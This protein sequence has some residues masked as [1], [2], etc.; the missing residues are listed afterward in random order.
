MI[1]L[2]KRAV[3]ALAARSMGVTTDDLSNGAERQ[4]SQRAIREQRLADCRRYAEFLTP[5]VD[6]WSEDS[7]RWNFGDETADMVR[8]MRDKE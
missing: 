4:K 6:E 3:T 2:Y 7:I 1:K 8:K 5:R